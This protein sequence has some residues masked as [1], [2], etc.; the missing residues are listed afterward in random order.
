MVQYNTIMYEM[1]TKISELTSNMEESKCKLQL[2]S[3]EERKKEKEFFLKIIKDYE[4]QRGGN[5]EQFERQCAENVSLQAHIDKLIEENYKLVKRNSLMKSQYDTTQTVM[6]EQIK[7]KKE[8]LQE[9][10]DLK[11]K[12]GMLTSMVDRAQIQ[13]S[14]IVSGYSVKEKVVEGILKLTHFNK[15]YFDLKLPRFIENKDL[16]TQIEALSKIKSVHEKELEMLSKEN[17]FLKQNIHAL[18]LAKGHDH[19]D[20]EK[21]PELNQNEIKEKEFKEIK[22]LHE[23]ISN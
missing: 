15:R 5:L 14:K 23:L 13:I 10:K 6:N 1:S 2:E 18:T 21:L 7:K 17:A 8:M 12:I 3:S 22:D 16:N 19:P 20:F 11:S 4:A 9:N